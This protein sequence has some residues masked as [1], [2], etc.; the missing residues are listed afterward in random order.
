MLNPSP[1][2]TTEYSLRDRY[3]I[4]IN[5]TLQTHLIAMTLAFEAESNKRPKGPW[6]EEM[7]RIVDAGTTELL[8]TVKALETEREERCGR[9]SMDN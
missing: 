1:S 9:L 5:H 2:P 7:H 6:T 4:L 3:R 8:E